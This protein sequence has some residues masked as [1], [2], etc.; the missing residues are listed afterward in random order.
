M[1]EQSERDVSGPPAGRYV[2]DGQIGHGGMATVWRARDTV[3]DRMVAL[4]RLRTGLRDDAESMARFLREARAVVRLSHPGVV[5]L[6]DR[7]E[8]AE[9]PY[10]VMELVDGEDLKARIAREGPLP[11]GEAARICAQVASTLSYAHSQGV[12]HR[13]IKSQ[14]VLIDAEGNVKLADFGIAHLLEV[15]TESG[16]TRSGMM[17]GTSDYL[18]PEQ[19][20]GRTVD[21]RADIYA[22]GI[23]LWECLTGELPFPGEN[24]VTVAMRQIND[25]LPD[26]R[27]LVPNVPRRLAAAVLRATQKNPDARYATAGEFAD[28]LR[29]CAAARPR[30]AG[31]ADG[32]VRSPHAG[33]ALRRRQGR[34]RLV[35]LV[36]AVLVVIGVCWRVAGAPPLSSAP[37]V[38]HKLPIRVTSYDPSG[39]G[40]EEPGMVRYATDGNPATSW[41]TEPHPGSATFDGTKHGVGLL[42]ATPVNTRATRIDLLSSTPGAHVQIRAPGQLTEPPLVGTTVLTGTVQQILLPPHT[43]RELVVWVTRLVPDPQVAGAFWAGVAEVSVWGV[44]NK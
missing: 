30:A 15:S 22:L 40:I 14:N 1:S 43:P 26:P 44:P 24:F 37:A 5:R 34:R 29:A 32:R 9:G 38:A 31:T 6:L 16:L 11:P 25:P 12:I 35:V 2:V 20:Q 19:A 17:V 33:V 27:E 21:G 41:Y 28:E 42:I 3:L 39:D 23:V 18:A 8:D 36:V 13:D 10:L 7:G 4:K